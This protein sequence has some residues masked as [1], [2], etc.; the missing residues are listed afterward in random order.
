[1]TAN[2][3]SKTDEKILC[4]R[5]DILSKYLG[6]SQVFCDKNLWEHILKNLEIIPRSQV[7]K[8]FRFKQ[9]VVYI[10]IKHSDTYLTY[11][12]TETRE[13]ML[14]GKYSIGIG[15]HVN[16]TDVNGIDKIQ[17][18]LIKKKLI[19]AVWREIN[20]EI[21]IKSK[22]ISDPKLKCFINDD[23]DEVGKLHFGSVWLL[24]I[25]EPKV[26]PKKGVGKIKFASLSELEME[27]YRFLE[28]W[29]QLLV[30]YN[31]FLRG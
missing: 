7:E 9:L 1:M 20:E 10:I 16:D 11:K 28:R 3:H 21:E 25:S 24:K 19:R 27:K 22:V 12:R 26:S 17:P 31:H 15:G 29:S 8:D 14:K 30:K 6:T 13:K 2:L 5:K 18:S 4:F 23:S